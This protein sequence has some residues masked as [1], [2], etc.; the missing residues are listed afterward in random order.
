MRPTPLVG[1]ALILCAVSLTSCTGLA[2]RPTGAP[3]QA[4]YDADKPGWAERY[5]PGFRRVVNL[6]PPP[7]EA[8]IK[9]DER[10]KRQHQS[11]VDGVEPRP[12]SY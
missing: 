7:T 11:W 4:G 3:V 6:L 12:A 8:R 1:L 5:I 10:M 2:V 9:W